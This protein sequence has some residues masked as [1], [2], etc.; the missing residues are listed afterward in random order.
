[1]KNKWIMK[2]IEKPLDK[3]LRWRVMLMLMRADKNN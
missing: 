1:L 2:N 3:E